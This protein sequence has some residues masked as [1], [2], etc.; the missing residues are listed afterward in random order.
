MEEIWN[1]KIRHLNWK[2]GKAFVEIE[3]Y[4]FLESAIKKLGECSYTVSLDLFQCPGI[5]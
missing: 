3:T 5:F 1:L 2:F 4:L